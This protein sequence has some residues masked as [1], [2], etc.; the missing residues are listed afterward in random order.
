MTY[1][2]SINRVAIT[3][4]DLWRLTS[5]ASEFHASGERDLEALMYL[6]AR[7]FKGE[8]AKAGAVLLRM[9]ALVQL[10]NVEGV[11]GWTLPK[12]ADGA[13]PVQEAVFEAAAVQPLVEIENDARF[14]RQLFLDKVL[15]LAE[16][17]G[18]A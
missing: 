14:D 1:L 8:P 3:F 15:E 5:Q 10:L 11:S 13:I 6:I 12:Q 18:N 17:E 9:Q 16:S 2:E 7:N 4:E